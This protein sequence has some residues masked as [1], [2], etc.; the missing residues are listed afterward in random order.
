M[1][2]LDHEI[3]QVWAETLEEENGLVTLP[4]TPEQLS[5]RLTA[6]IITNYIDTEKISFERLF[7]FLIFLKH[8]LKR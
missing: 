8:I 4:P 6:P 7:T 2:E 1:I 3:H 5:Q